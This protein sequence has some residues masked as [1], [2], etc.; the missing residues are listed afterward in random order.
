[1]LLLD[2]SCGIDYMGLGDEVVALII[3]AII[4]SKTNIG[5]KKAKL[6]GCCMLLLL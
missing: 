4:F 5:K 2:E 3:F 1:M 6:I